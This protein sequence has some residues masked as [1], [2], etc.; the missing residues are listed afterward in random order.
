MSIANELSSEV[1]EAL[2]A[3]RRDDSSQSAR[4]LA[5]VV[6]EVHSTL[7]RLTAESRRG[8]ARPRD[9]AGGS[10]DAA[11]AAGAGPSE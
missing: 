5:G 4:D 1:A 8:K 6:K 9:G 10:H 11:N 7:R 2:L 3:R